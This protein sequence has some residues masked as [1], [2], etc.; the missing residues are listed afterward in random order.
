ML[1]RQLK[2]LSLGSDSVGLV[3]GDDSGR[4]VKLPAVQQ[5]TD[6]W[7]A[8]SSDA[9][10]LEETHLVLDC[11]GTDVRAHVVSSDSVEKCGNISVAFS[12]AVE[13]FDDDSYKEVTEH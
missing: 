4:L 13:P 8:A 9:E 5:L 12:T 7:S 3:T 2:I 11:S 1:L 10:E 6:F